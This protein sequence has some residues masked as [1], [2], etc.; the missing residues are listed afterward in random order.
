[1]VGLTQLETRFFGY[2]QSTRTATVATGDLA[3]AVGIA[4][5]QE[6]RVLSRLSRRGLIARVRRGLYLVPPRIPPGGRWSPSEALALA[7]LMADQKAR[8]QI[9]GP[10]AFSRYGWDEQVS[11][12]VF[13]YNNRMS[14][15]R[16][17]GAVELTLVKV[18]DKRLGATDIAETP[19]GIPLFYASRARALMDAVYDW[20]RFNTVPRAFDWI[21]DELRRDDRIAADLVSVTLKY[22]NQGTLRRIGKVLEVAGASR[23]LLRKIE[24]SLRPTTSFIPWIPTQ[25]KR[26][27]TDKR[28]MLLLNDA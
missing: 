28:W 11:N 5:E 26:G 25:R 19:E 14:G 8:Y 27:T 16:S 4:P 12:S 6:K 7:T 24:R 23:P 10:N 17:I 13:V 18:A 15:E 3:A 1:M 9:S 2:T 21:R 20:S 22:G